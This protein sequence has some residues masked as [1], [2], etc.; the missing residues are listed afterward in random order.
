MLV[1]GSPVCAAA[2]FFHYFVESCQHCHGSLP[3]FKV[4]SAIQFFLISAPAKL[5][6]FSEILLCVCVHYV[7]FRGVSLSFFCV[8]MMKFSY[9]TSHVSSHLIILIIEGICS[10]FIPIFTDEENKLVEDHT[11]RKW[12]P[13]TLAP[14]SLT[15]PHQDF[16]LCHSC[17]CADPTSVQPGHSTQIGWSA[18]ILL[19]QGSGFE[20]TDKYCIDSHSAYCGLD[21][22]TKFHSPAKSLEFIF[23]LNPAIIHS[24]PRLSYFQ[25][26]PFHLTH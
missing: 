18:Q 2:D 7:C 19:T 13:S 12:S 11:L 3:H 15:P 10:L 16:S 22:F 14:A 6:F 21:R 5:Y 4:T 9:N 8:T 1:V 17:L 26:N 24:L 25:L 20:G 23:F